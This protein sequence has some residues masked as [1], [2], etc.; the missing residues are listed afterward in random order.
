MINFGL[1]T[2]RQWGKVLKAL[3][4]SFLSAFI[5]ALTAQGGFQVGL[6]WEGTLALFAGAAVAGVNGVLY[7]AYI[8]FFEGD[9]SG[10]AE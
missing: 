3:I 9:G 6:G 4:F 5:T 1:P 10:K 2:E 7:A 8:T